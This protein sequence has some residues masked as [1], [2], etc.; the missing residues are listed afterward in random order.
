LAALKEANI[1]DSLPEEEFDDIVRI[2]S[3]VCGTPMAVIGLID[4]DRQW[5]KA[6]VGV[7]ADQ[8]S[9]DL[10][11]CAHTI[12][13]ENV[14]EVPDAR[15]DPRFSDNPF[16]TTEPGIRFYAGAPLR[17]PEGHAIGTLCVYDLQPH[18]LSKQQREALEALGRLVMARIESRR[19]LARAGIQPD[20]APAGPST[21]LAN[22]VSHELA[23]PLTAAMLQVRGLRRLIE[24]GTPEQR[25]RALELLERNVNRLGDAAA[26]IVRQAS[27]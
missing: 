17:T 13:Q 5:Y 2:A 23:T 24:T 12:L 6:K 10:S 3:H 7:A 1:L 14:L 8:V 27:R 16:V 11:F 4:R 22:A 15:K 25:A 18:S 26:R 9:R 21:A 20:A 19:L